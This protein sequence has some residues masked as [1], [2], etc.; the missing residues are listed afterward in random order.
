MWNA[1]QYL[2]FADELSRPFVDQ[3]SQI[4]NDDF[5]LVAGFRCGT[6][7]LTRTLIER[8]PDA[9]TAGQDWSAQRTV[10]PLM[11]YVHLLQDLGLRVNAWETTYYHLIG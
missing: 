5:R 4:Q 11:S 7:S 1:A 6:G 10:K 2:E 9:R 8:W 3:K